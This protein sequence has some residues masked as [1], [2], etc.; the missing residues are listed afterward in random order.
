MSGI[1]FFVFQAELSF[2]VLDEAKGSLIKQKV[3]K[4]VRIENK[5]KPKIKN[6]EQNKILSLDFLLLFDQA[7]S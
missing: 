4:I 2:D 5:L 6:A 3:K 1:K 7:K